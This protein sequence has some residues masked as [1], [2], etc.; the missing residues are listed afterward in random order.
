LTRLPEEKAMRSPS[1][2]PPPLRRAFCLAVLLIASCVHA[3]AQDSG[4]ALPLGQAPGA[5][6]GSYPL[7]DFDTVNFFNGHLNFRLPLAAAGGRGGAAHTV[8]FVY[9]QKWVVEHYFDP[10]TQQ[11]VY[12][13]SDNWRSGHDP[14][15]SPG[16]VQGYTVRFF[17]P[18]VCPT[19]QSLR[20]H[21]QTLS[22]LTFS[23]PDGT[24]YNLYSPHGRAHHQPCSQTGF[25][26]GRVFSSADGSA[27]TFVVEGDDVVEY[28]F[29]NHPTEFTVSGHLYLRDGTRYRVVDGRVTEVRDRNG[30]RLSV[31]YDGLGR[32]ETV[33]DPLGRQITVQYNFQDAA[34]YGTCTRVLFNG[35]GGAQRIVRI[36]YASLNQALRPGLTN[37]DPNYNP[38]LP[39]SVWLPDGLR[40][41]R[42]YYNAYAELARVELPTGGAVEY[43]HEGG[44]Q[45]GD[46]E[47]I[48]E[49]LPDGTGSHAAHIYRRVVERRVYP[50]GVNLRLRMTV[51]KPEHATTSQS[52]GYVEVK[53]YEKNP[54]GSETLLARER[55][56]FIGSA[57]PTIEQSAFIDPPSGAEITGREYRTEVFDGAGPLL[58]KVEHAWLGGSAQVE[59]AHVTQTLTTLSD[60]GQVSK[61]EYAYDRYQ[62][63]TDTWEY[64]YGT[65]PGS[66]GAFLRR[67]HADYVTAAD[68]VNSPADAAP[69]AHLRSLPAQVRVSSDAGGANVMTRT[70]YAYDIHASDS[71]HAPLVPRPG[72]TGH[73]ASYSASFTRRG[74]VTDVTSYANAAG[75]TPTGGV[76]TS[77]QYD[78][79]GN[80]VK[81]IDPL[82]RANE[83]TYGDSFCNGATCGGA[84]T[85]NTYA[86]PTA[87]TSPVPDP[88]GQYGS[89]TALTTSTVY[90]FSTGLVTSTTDANSQTTT[91]SYADELGAL[92]PLDRLRKVVRPGGMAAGG[93]G[94]TLYDYG[95]TA[96]NLF[97]R[98]RTAI[99]ASRSLESYQYFDGFGRSFRSIRYE[100]QDPAKP[101][102]TADTEY[103]ALGRVKRAS[104]PYRAA[105]GVTLFSTD[106][107]SETAYDALGRVKAVKTM[108][109]TA[110]VATDYAGNAV[111]VIDQ[112][113]KRRRSVSD[114][115]GRLTSVTEAPEVS[116][117]QPDG[118][119][120][121]T[122]YTYDALG[123]LRKVEQGT[124]LRYFMYDSL[125]RLIRA[126]NPEQDAMAA[127]DDFPALT[128]STSGTSN[129]VWSVGY[130]YDD[131]GNLFKR[132]D[133][134]NVKTTY[135]YDAL[136]RNTSVDYSD[137]TP[138]VSR[139]YDNAAQDAYGK[140]RLWKS[141]TQGAA[142]TRVVVNAYDALG[143]PLSQT[144]EFNTA[145][146]WK[147]FG[148][149]QTY[150]R[151]GNVL[152]RKYPSGRS[153]DYQYDVA[154][155][156][157]EFRGTLGDG[158]QRTYAD[159]VRYHELGGM[160]QERFGTD[161][162]LYHKRFYNVRGQ[163]GD[164]RLS[165]Y[166]ITAPG[167]AMNWNRGAVVNH[168]SQAVWGGSDSQNNGNL[169]TQQVWVPSDDGASVWALFEQSYA[170][171]A[172]N[173]L[174]RVGEGGRWQQE[175][176]YDRWGNRTVNAAGTW[177]A[178]PS[179]PPTNLV[180]ERQFD[181]GALAATNRLYAP[182]DTGLPEA[183]RR[184]RYDAAGNLTQDYCMEGRPEVCARAYD[185]EGRMTSAQFLNGQV[186]SLSH[187]YDADG[188]RV[189]RGS[190]DGE[191]WQVYGM[192]GELLA[193]YAPNAPASPQ[194]EYGYRAGELLVTAE[195]GAPAPTNL[196]LGKP[197][198]QSSVL[199]GGV[200]S[201][202]TDG[203]TDG[204]W[205]GGSV[206][207]T[208]NQAQ[209]WWQV[210]LG[211]VQQLQTVRVWNRTDCC[212]ERLSNFYVLVSDAPFTSTDL[213]VTLSQAGVS[214][215][216]VAGP[217]AASAAVAVGRTGRYVR[218]QLAAS[219]DC[220][221]LA[222]V[223]ALGQAV[224]APTN[225]AQGKPATQSSD[226]F[227][228]V[229]SRAVDGNTSGLWSGNSVTHTDNQAQPWWQVDL[230]AVQSLQTVR[231]WN[232]TDCCSERLS[233]FYVLVSD[234]PFASTSLSATLAQ[235]GVS[236]FHTPGP[237]GTSVSVSVNRTGRY[238]RVQL[239]ASADC[240][241][242]AEVEVLGQAAGGD[243][244]LGWLV[245]DQLGTPRM[246]IDKSGSL[247]GV[248]RHDYFP[249]G[250]E[251]GAGVGGRTTQQ[252]YGLPNNIRQRWAKLE[253]DDET[254]LDYAQ[255]RYYS[256]AMGR[257][258]SPDEFTGG[259]DE[260]F[261]F[262]A[263][264]ADNP[265]FYADLTNPQSLNKYQYAYNNPL[266]Y[267][268]PEGHCPQ[269]GVLGSICNIAVGS[270]AISPVLVPVAVLVITAKIIDSVPGSNTEGDGSC[271]SCD[272]HIKRF[273]Q[274]RDREEA[275]R[276]NIRNQ[277]NSGNQ[278]N[279]NQPSQPG[280]Q[281]GNTPQS[282]GHDQQR[283]QE[284]RSGQDPRRDVGDANRVI[285]DGK[286]YV[287]SETGNIVH[288]GK[289]GHTVITDPTGERIVTR[290]TYKKSEIEKR[291]RSGKWEPQ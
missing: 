83:V 116:T 126:K 12:Y 257:F 242:L 193:E 15:F 60:T 265:T 134:R 222:E 7:S 171:D 170:Y 161:A 214:S 80:P 235:P 199:F 254:E 105:A 192:G 141:E 91:L 247:A 45:G 62:N 130:K 178:S 77:T 181:G 99:D 63:R 95:D 33:T 135:A 139:F 164:I 120:C 2:L 198:T 72:I 240:L 52:T 226:L 259:P 14:G 289:K 20:T 227:G 42:L 167:Q 248:R 117:C 127:D 123:N 103:D 277:D 108:P 124:Q 129:G 13:A 100:N 166:P 256:P 216:H 251:I 17:A 156:L 136:N 16:V 187:T 284:G 107:W 58:R 19:N 23:A 36:S 87:T 195:A 31:G 158:V 237:A 253:R 8:P 54:D 112:A 244:Q 18:D 30:N 88:T 49:G 81:S 209:P 196:A 169:R 255:A 262:V 233:N 162:P 236:A 208:D 26:R 188:R 285:R 231:L 153:V 11:N 122:S 109:D 246:V 73:D 224:A 279:N 201:R 10:V 202:A 55:H 94:Q 234:A 184:M 197:A 142:G 151:A 243:A 93:G 69:G 115:L 67:T 144:Q 22:Y 98:T 28:P 70:D 165:T 278:G 76:T 146:G 250:E 118:A 276:Q 212:S 132:K 64:D 78:V 239:A 75:P 172:L 232:R 176:D 145:N 268:D 82:A 280:Q 90:D 211:A 56:H 200:A 128:D 152:T 245:T 177:L 65:T 138:D 3:V 137:A 102:I 215:Y 275:E 213:N 221:A 71:R 125:S 104:L 148:T 270:P 86:F 282:T 266:R 223:E 68:Y 210:D 183:Q 207:H 271:T 291:V 273:Q 24:Q 57:R 185:A 267:N 241:A 92:D 264:A 51:S 272:A 228:G 205:G 37:P 44:L 180:N 186:Q 121:T 191:V 97:V 4:G 159:D 194:K 50:D 206:T 290:N 203:N 29:P 174:K 110:T 85:P 27:A 168:Y 46:P 131:A 173:R 229:A 287:D 175:Y 225:L 119:G 59:G 260:L 149:E 220:L 286:K 6:A 219:A 35:F 61:Q 74:N 101:W 34:P 218:V 160:E 21:P 263:D 147:A 143:R 39:V 189:K 190:L 288:V 133:A 163:L 113:G 9:E 182:G 204:A 38:L 238:V 66:V 32:V 53:Q 157:S 41:Y 79:A 249:F 43:D 111:T 84:F 179:A 25:N 283:K 89:Q 261:D 114:A 106:R 155:R 140:G 217:V 274:R 40:R 150:D 1:Y 230:G 258:T 5:P 48:F 252:G 96:G 154:G 269:E 47:G 281:Q